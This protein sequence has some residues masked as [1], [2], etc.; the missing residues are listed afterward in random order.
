MEAETLLAMKNRMNT[1][2]FT[3]PTIMDEVRSLLADGRCMVLVTLEKTEGSTPRDT[4][5]F[6][7]V[8]Q[9]HFYGTIGGGQLE[10][11]A[12]EEARAILQTGRLDD[13]FRSTR[14]VVLGP[15]TGQCCGGRV[16][17]LFRPLRAALLNT[18]EEEQERQLVP[19]VQI[20]GAGHTGKALGNALAGLPFDVT[21]IDSRA[22]QLD[23]LSFKTILTPLPEEQ[24]RM[25]GARTAFVILTHSHQLDFL[26]AAEALKRGDAAYVG[27]IGSRTKRKVFTN[28]LDANG[29]E[30]KLADKLV[31]PIG[32][33]DVKDKRP[34]IIGALVCAELIRAFAKAD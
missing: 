21:V 23:N 7:L 15:E 25:A 14:N 6:M 31:C 1:T 20:H 2:D 26:L 10:W 13:D 30:R 9:E 11:I 12:L 33:N 27:M 5:A 4:D 32:G 16:A 18:L 34:A 22:D 19:C 8:T 29:Y 3:C 24:V 17:L 28:W